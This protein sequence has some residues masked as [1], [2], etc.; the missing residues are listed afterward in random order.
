MAVHD[1]HGVQLCHIPVTTLLCT[2]QQKQEIIV[3]WAT[4]GCRCHASSSVASA[5]K[6]LGKCMFGMQQMHEPD[7]TIHK[8]VKSKHSAS[9]GSS[10]RRGGL[11]GIRPTWIRCRSHVHGHIVHPEGADTAQ[12]RCFSRLTSLT[13][14]SSSHLGSA[15]HTWHTNPSCKRTCAIHKT[16]C[17]G[18]QALNNVS[19]ARLCMHSQ[20][21]V[22]LAQ[23]SA[24]DT[25]P[26]Q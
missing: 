1:L 3:A 2:L 8:C 6:H 9:R 16:S 11:P 17:V 18:R 13:A 21:L 7:A 10:H 15:C 24:S 22:Y 12:P 23:T 26:W 5:T 19:T 25:H 20:Q 4:L 14:C